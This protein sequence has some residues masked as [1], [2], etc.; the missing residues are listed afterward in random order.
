MLFCYDIIAPSADKDFCLGSDVYEQRRHSMGTD[1]RGIGFH[2][3]AGSSP[4]LWRNG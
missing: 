2:N 3:D 1:K 4:F